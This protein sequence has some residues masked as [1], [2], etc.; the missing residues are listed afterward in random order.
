MAIMIDALDWGGV[1]FPVL[2]PVMLKN[3]AHTL[4]A[5]TSLATRNFLYELALGIYCIFMFLMS[6]VLGSLSNKYGP[7][8]ILIVSMPGNFL[9]FLLARSRLECTVSLFY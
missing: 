6:P 2:D 5:T 4:N 7:K 8:I 1:A 9:G 3:S